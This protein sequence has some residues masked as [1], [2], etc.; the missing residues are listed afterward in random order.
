M[1]LHLS[2]HSGMSGWSNHCHATRERIRTCHS[3][4]GRDLNNHRGKYARHNRRLSSH[5]YSSM[6]HSS[7]SHVLSNASCK[8]D[9]DKL[10]HPNQARKHKLS[11]ECS[12][13]AQSS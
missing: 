4:N 13:R 5:R 11:L 7:S 8:V 2:T 12:C 10:S 1:C 6:S 3:C 9:S